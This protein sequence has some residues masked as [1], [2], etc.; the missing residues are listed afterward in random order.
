M[1]DDLFAQV[2]AASIPLETK[3]DIIEHY[4]G[5]YGRTWAA[6]LTRD[7]SPI[8]GKAPRNLA[9]RFNPDRINNPEP[10]NAEQYKQLGKQL[11][12]KAPEGGY[13]VWGTI[14]VKYSGDC[15]E[16]E[17]DFDVI[18]EDADYLASASD[19]AQRQAINNIYNGYTSDDDGYDS[20]N[21]WDIHV[22]PIE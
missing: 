12:G 17:V 2:R 8:A 11:P 9:R 3:Q 10:R 18:G 6:H 22:E 5:E 1:G 20:C 14:Q 21:G 7:L 16:R 15:E 19:A 13:H 4:Q